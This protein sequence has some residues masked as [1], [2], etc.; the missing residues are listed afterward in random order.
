MTTEPSPK[1][2]IAAFAEVQA[3][4]SDPFGDRDVTLAL[5]GL[6]ER[7]W[8]SI[9]AA[10]IARLAKDDDAAAVLAQAYG[11]AFES[12]KKAPG[13]QRG[14]KRSLAEAMAEATA[15]PDLS[16]SGSPSAT[17]S[18]PPEIVP[19]PDVAPAAFS[20]ASPSA[21]PAV[22]PL[23]IPSFLRDRKAESPGALVPPPAAPP[24]MEAPLATS[25]TPGYTGTA[26]VD[27]A[28]IFKSV[29]PFDPSAKESVPANPAP[30]AAPARDPAQQVFNGAS[31]APEAARPP[32]SLSKSALS[33]ETADVDIGAIARQVLAF[34]AARPAAPSTPSPPVVSPPV[35]SPPVARPAAGS[36]PAA[37][38]RI[39]IRPAG[40]PV[41]SQNPTFTLDQYAQLSAEIAHDSDAAARS[42]VFARYGVQSSD[43]L[44][45]EWRARFSADP[46]LAGRWSA[47]YAHHYARLMAERGPR[48]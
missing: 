45:T 48:R 31:S 9:E 43:A 40:A 12:A 5:R 47:A 21:S 25:P 6:D 28:A 29:V 30:A 26:A 23:A 2:N 46:A 16:A 20:A 14:Q 35:V 11:D 18:A 15:R 1:D 3:S 38:D 37:S 27:I 39:V 13:K 44:A 34:G 41:P 24:A 19:T 7:A 42:T 36:P 10:W 22:K 33:G 17:A 4:L 32:A 8:Q